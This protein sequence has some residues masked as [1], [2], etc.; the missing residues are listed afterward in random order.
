M[1]VVTNG[2]IA[3]QQALIAQG[4]TP[5]SPYVC[6]VAQLGSP[7]AGTR[8]LVTDSTATLAAGL[9]NVVAGRGCDTVPVYADGTNWRIG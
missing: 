3:D 9:G 5:I 7:A 6:T 1:V 2:S 8:A 4:C